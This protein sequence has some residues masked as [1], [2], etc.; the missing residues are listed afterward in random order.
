MQISQL[1]KGKKSFVFST[2]KL[3]T[4]KLNSNLYIEEI[5]FK[6]ILSLKAAAAPSSKRVGVWLIPEMHPQ[7]R[8]ANRAK[9]FL[10]LSASIHLWAKEPP[11]K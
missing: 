10:A 9:K 6:R 3:A 11:T 8:N 7:K 1:H 4:I 2:Q 5:V